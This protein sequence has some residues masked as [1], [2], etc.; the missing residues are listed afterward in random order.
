MFRAFTR[1]FQQLADLDNIFRGSFEQ[2]VD[3]PR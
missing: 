2:Y 3:L 1:G